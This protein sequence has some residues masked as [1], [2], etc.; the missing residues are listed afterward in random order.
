VG[1]PP[2]IQASDISEDL[3]QTNLYA[4]SYI[5]LIPN[6]TFT[7][8]LSADWF[9]TDSLDSKDK[10]RVNPKFGVIWNP[11]PSTTIRAA[12][13][14]GLKRTLINDQTLEPT[15]VAGFNQFFDDINATESW[16]Y[17][18]AINQKFSH[19]IYGGAEFSY[20]DVEIPFSELNVITG[21]NRVQD[22]D[23]EEYQGRAYLFWT[24]HPWV[25]LRAEYQYE[26]FNR[27][28][29]VAFFFKQMNTHKVPLGVTLFH[30]AGLSFDLQVTYYN[31]DGDFRNNSAPAGGFMHGSTDF[32]LMNMAINYRL[33][34]RYGLITLGG[35]NIFDETFEYQETDLRN[36][37]IQ[38]DRF[39]FGKV[40][41]ALP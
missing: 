30:P 16:R 18:G 34:K 25:A 6:V 12:A 35:T 5:N 14:R 39:F 2:Q 21:R 10:T 32:W 37:T 4:Y 11:T 23:G 13:F 3:H 24:P 41:L 1:P 29:I 8:G 19:N 38:P 15:Q 7:A 20:R 27:E 33:P 40:T 22:G 31:Q 26:R 28:D 17:G 9:R 36:P